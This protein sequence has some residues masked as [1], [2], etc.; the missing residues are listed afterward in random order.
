[1]SVVLA[2]Q[3]AI[4]VTKAEYDIIIYTHEAEGAISAQHDYTMGLA[5]AEEESH[6]NQNTT[7]PKPIANRAK[8]SPE[9]QGVLLINK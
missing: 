1:M 3:R 8:P 6:K 2:A 7:N 9:A 4:G 5:N